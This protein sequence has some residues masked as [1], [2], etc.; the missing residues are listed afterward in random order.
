MIYTLLFIKMAKFYERNG[1]YME[2]KHYVQVDPNDEVTYI[3]Y[4]IEA[5]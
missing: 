2:Q 1:N 5:E 4:N 3:S